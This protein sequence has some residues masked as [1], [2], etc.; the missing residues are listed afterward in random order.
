[1]IKNSKIKSIS[2]AINFDE[3]SKEFFRELHNCKNMN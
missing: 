3:K 1:M 2:R